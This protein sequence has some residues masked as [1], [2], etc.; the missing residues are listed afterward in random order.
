MDKTIIYYVVL[1]LKS[2]KVFRLKAQKAEW[3][4]INFFL[5]FQNS[6]IVSDR[7]IQSKN[8]FLTDNELANWTKMNNIIRE[9][10]ITE[11]QTEPDSHNTTHIGWLDGN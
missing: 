11:D 5:T 1:V 8:H 6:L 7:E 10:R 3:G 4:H 2:L 9:P